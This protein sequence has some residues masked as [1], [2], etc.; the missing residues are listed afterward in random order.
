MAGRLSHPESQ[1]ENAARCYAAPVLSLLPEVA[2]GFIIALPAHEA[3][4][5]LAARLLGAR[6]V[7]LSRSGRFG[8]RVAATFP[9][10]ARGRRALFLAAGALG[11]VA[12]AA[13]ALLLPAAAHAPVLAGIQVLFAAL[14][15]VPAG[16]TDG[17]RLLSLLGERR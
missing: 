5:A 1:G 4:H 11:N 10:D 7:Q 8:A 14:T 17:A 13:T 12:V 9:D 3:G 15:L 6:D 2:L 16:D